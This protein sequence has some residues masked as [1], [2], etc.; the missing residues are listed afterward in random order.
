M[1][2]SQPAAVAGVQYAQINGWLPAANSNVRADTWQKRQKRLK[3][4]QTMVWAHCKHL[5]WQPVQGKARL[6]VTFV[7][8]NQRRRDYDGLVSRVKGVVDGLV[9]GGWIEDDDLDHLDLQVR[10]EVHTGRK[11]LGLMLEPLA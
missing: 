11:A 10:S 9:K 1:T 8:P 7:F 4:A 2:H 5:G 6:T 3:A